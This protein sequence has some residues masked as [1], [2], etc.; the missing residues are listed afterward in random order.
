MELNISGTYKVIVDD[1]DAH[2]L[3][4]WRWHAHVTG[5]NVYARGYPIGNRKGGLF[6]LHR[7]ILGVN[8]RSSDVDHR[9]GNGL[10]NRRTNLRL[11]SR[12][13]NNANRHAVQSYSSPFKGVH[14]ETQTGRWRAEVMK[15]GYRYRLGRFDSIE[16]A[17]AAYDAKAR[18]LFPGFGH[19][20]TNS[21]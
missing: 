12:S 21:K 20:S 17:A 19:G 13:Q 14:Y 18:E 5:P 6:Y 8:D 11:A 1:T 3:T 10:D 4:E 15:D 2:L 7:V 9:N 16:E